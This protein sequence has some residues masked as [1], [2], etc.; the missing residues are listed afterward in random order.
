MTLAQDIMQTKVVTV[1]PEMPVEELARILAE[2]GISGAPVVDESGDLVGV[3]SL[4]DLILY[5][6]WDEGGRNEFDNF[7][8]DGFWLDLEYFTRTFQG[9]DLTLRVKDVMSTTC[10][11]VGE[12]TPLHNITSLMQLKGIHRLVVTKEQRRVVGIISSLDLVKYL[13]ELLTADLKA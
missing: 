3:V 5:G 8:R 1:D 10:Y 4:T 13:G 9:V 7:H 6:Q 11:H 12:H 2:K